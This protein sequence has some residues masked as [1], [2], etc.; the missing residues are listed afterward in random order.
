MYRKLTALLSFALLPLTLL[1]QDPAVRSVDV[2][3]LLYEDGGA[4]INERWD[5][6]ATS[7]TEWYLVRENLGDIVISDLKVC[8]SDGEAF[9]NEGAWD[10]NRDIFAKARRCGI[11]RTGR[12]CEICWGIGSYGDHVFNVSYRMTN[13]VKTLSDA[14]ALHMQF[15]SPG[16]SPSPRQAS[17]TIHSDL[18]PFTQANSSIWAFG[19]YGEIAYSASGAIVARSLQPFVRESSVIVL[20]RFDKGIF[21]SGSVI[22]T[23]F[24]TVKTTAFEGSTYQQW[25]DSNE[26]A[27][28]SI[29]SVFIAVLSGMVLV[30]LASVRIRRKMNMKVFGVSKIKEIGYARDVPFNGD[31]F[32]SN[33]IYSKV[34]SGLPAGNIASAIILRMIKNG[35][36][37]IVN[38]GN[39]K[40]QLSFPQLPSTSALDALSAP[41]RS[42]YD[43]VREASGSD[44]VLQKHEFPRWA[45]RHSSRV[46]AWA[47]SILSEGVSRLRRDGYVSSRTYT[48]QGQENARNVVGLRNFLKD[49]TLLKERGSAEVALW[50]DYIVFAALFGIADKVAK[51]LEEIDPDAF[52]QVVGYDYPTMNRMIILSNNM[53]SSITEGIRYAQTSASVRGG[54]GFS[55]FGGGGGFSGGGFGGGSR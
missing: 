17:V 24:E 50:H 39:G 38:D 29:L 52:R 34:K 5:V 16:I 45:R 48:P 26:D 54:G 28:K 7:G 41:E 47:D 19:F 51:E 2:D 18:G 10:V 30:V 15:I 22:D 9:V 14:D 21:S 31:L 12:G 37:G 44:L 42:L 27:R 36:I 20:A 8:D 55:S 23:D 11:V 43:M 13:V 49:F 40:V 53:S 35:Q 32:E 4:L 46:S 6:C 3:V 1:C 33:V 25:L